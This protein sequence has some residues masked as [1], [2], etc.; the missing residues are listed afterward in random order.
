MPHPVRSLAT[1][2]LLLSVG[3][4]LAQGDAA[5]Y[6][7]VA[8]IEILQAKSVQADLK[9]TEAQRAKLNA[10]ADWYNKGTEAALKAAG[11]KPS[12]AQ[13]R[14]ARAKLGAL[15]RQL[16]DRVLGELTSTQLRRLSQISL[17]RL[18]ILAVLDETIAARI[19]LSAAQRKTIGD[20]WNETGQKVAALERRTREPIYN[21]Y[22]DRKPKDEADAKRLQG[23]YD[24][25]MSEVTTKN[26]PE[27]DRL[28]AGFEGVVS[29]TLTAGQKK[30]W[31]D[32]KGPAFKV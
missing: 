14:D 8:D 24:K 5:F 20:S 7:H 4:A 17:Q 23:A 21:R 30:T 11:E 2:G 28:K 27:V 18:G 32:L 29:R 13:Q 6:R 19:G 10:H 3:T 1:A 26:K 22:K 25:E 12:E 15:Q 31:E 16:R 9:V